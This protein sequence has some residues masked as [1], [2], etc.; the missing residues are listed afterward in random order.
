MTMLDPTEEIAIAD[1]FGVA[2]DQVRRDHLISHLLAVLSAHFAD[3]LIFFGG[4]ALC[5]S[6]VPNGRLSEDIDLIAVGNRRDTARALEQGLVA[7]NRREY[8]GMNWRPQLSTVRDVDP[9]VLATAEGLNVRI[10]LLNRTGYPHWPTESRAL[11]QRYS[12]VPPATLTVPTRA[13]F[14]AWKASAWMDRAAS[15]DLFDLWSLA[16]IGAIDGEAA[17]LF[18]RYGPMSR[19]ADEG[20]FS[21]APDETVWRRDLGAQTRVTVTADEALAVVRAAWKSAAS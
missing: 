2:R 9:A 7:E 3:Q 8:P 16:E 4:T 14:A 12:D 18:S 5:R 17:D 21:V 6:F 19:P 20:A 10:Q 1:Q 13:A 15:R 11:I